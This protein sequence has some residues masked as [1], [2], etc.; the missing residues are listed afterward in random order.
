M[1]QTLRPVRALTT[2]MLVATSVLTFAAVP[3]S[4]LLGADASIAAS[5]SP[6]PVEVG[7]QLT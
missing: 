5:A 1:R 3:A 7:E 4:A 2:F 6:D